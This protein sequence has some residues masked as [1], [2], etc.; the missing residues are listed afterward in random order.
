MQTFCPLS[1]DIESATSSKAFSMTLLVFNHKLCFWPGH[2][3]QQ[4]P[5]IMI[6]HYPPTV[7]TGV[8]TAQGLVK[9][10]KCNVA[11]QVNVYDVK[12][13]FYFWTVA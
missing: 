3:C 11:M 6:L 10:L 1:G 4:G 9:H 13:G 7:Q 2:F 8:R 12:E 5:K